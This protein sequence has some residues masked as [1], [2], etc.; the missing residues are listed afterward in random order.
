MAIEACSN[1]SERNMK[2]SGYVVGNKL[3]FDAS[4]LA[5]FRFASVVAI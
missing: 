5:A 4:F 1:A 2:S 3:L